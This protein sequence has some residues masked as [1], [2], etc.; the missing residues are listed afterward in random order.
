MP[1]IGR[2]TRGAAEVCGFC[3]DFP[4]LDSWRCDDHH[5]DVAALS[6]TP[7]GLLCRPTPLSTNLYR[8]TFLASYAYAC[9]T[10]EACPLSHT[11]NQG[12]A[13]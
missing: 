5:D 8:G 11:G 10:N 6:H 3:L 4:H 9:A 1:I 12:R 2:R 7:R 13:S